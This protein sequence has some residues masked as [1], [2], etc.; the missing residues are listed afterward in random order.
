MAPHIALRVSRELHKLEA[1]RLA[2]TA[3]EVQLEEAG[4]VRDQDSGDPFIEVAR[5]AQSLERARTLLG[6]ATAELDKIAGD[7]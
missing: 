4:I 2:L 1:V 6:E 3:A 7:A 5:A